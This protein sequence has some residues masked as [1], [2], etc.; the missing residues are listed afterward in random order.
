MNENNKLK[1]I[2]FTDNEQEIFDRMTPEEQD[3]VI[4]KKK[5]AKHLGYDGKEKNMFVKR[6]EIDKAKNDILKNSELNL[7]D[8][9]SNYLEMY[10]QEDTN[11]NI[12]NLLREG[13]VIY[14][15]KCPFLGN[16]KSHDCCN[17]YKERIE[18]IRDSVPI[19]VKYALDF[20]NMSQVKS[21]PI[22]VAIDPAKFVDE[23]ILKRIKC[24]KAER[25][26]A[27]REKLKKI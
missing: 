26:K 2:T 7:V 12:T 4:K 14:K 9:Y 27:E 22:S 11:K 13:Y 24:R 8:K 20:V 17:I 3:L 6:K 25:D 16:F 1:G 15:E 19:L 5:F 18:K 21:P 23:E 10:K